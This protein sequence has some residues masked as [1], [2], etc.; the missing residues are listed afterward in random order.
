M[1]S[2]RQKQ[3]GELIKRNFSLLLQQE[4]RYIYGSEALVTVTNVRMSPDLGIAKVYL[5]VFNH[6][7]KQEVIL[8]MEDQTTHLRQAL[9]SRIRRQIR[10]I[11][12]LHFYLDDTL[13]EMYRLNALFDRLEEEKQ[14]G[15]E[16]E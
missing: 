12:E 4:G 7:S 9:G 11:P 14:M 15:E 16:E 2:I 13:D 1:E 3:I 10:R 6:Q 5:S 8:E